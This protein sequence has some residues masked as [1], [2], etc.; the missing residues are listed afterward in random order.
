MFTTAFKGFEGS[1]ETKLD[2]AVKNLKQRFPGTIGGMPSEGV[3]QEFHDVLAAK[4]I[5]GTRLWD[6]PGVVALQVGLSEQGRPLL[7][8]IVSKPGDVPK[9]PKFLTVPASG[10]IVK[11]RARAVGYALSLPKSRLAAA[12]TKLD[13]LLY[14]VQGYRTAGITYINGKPT[15]AAVLLDKNDSGK[16][17]SD[18]D[19]FPIRVLYLA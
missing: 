6:T 12:R 11:V 8:V 7:D 14:N 2:A 19:G 17:P 13:Q 3:N 10:G 16:L 9:I 4:Q 1:T 18:V 5:Y 15:L